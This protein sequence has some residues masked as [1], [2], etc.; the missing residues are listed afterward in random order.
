MSGL[1]NAGLL[2]FIQEDRGVGGGGSFSQA[3][4]RKCLTAYGYPKASPQIWLKSHMHTHKLVWSM[5]S[6]A[7]CVELCRCVFI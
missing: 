6:L 7:G 4:L 1:A 5:G 3:V 2:V